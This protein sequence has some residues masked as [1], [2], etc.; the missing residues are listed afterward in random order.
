MIKFSALGVWSHNSASFKTIQ[1]FDLDHILTHQFESERVEHPPRLYDATLKTIFDEVRISTF[2][3]PELI[4]TGEMPTTFTSNELNAVTEGFTGEGVSSGFGQLVVAM[5]VVGAGT[6]WSKIPR[7]RCQFRNRNRNRFF[8]YRGPG[9]S[10]LIQK[11][12]S[13]KYSLPIRHYLSHPGNRVPQQSSDCRIHVDFPLNFRLHLIM[14]F[15][16][17]GMYCSHLCI[18]T[19]SC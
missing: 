8:R 1:Y 7:F 2:G 14:A 12:L 9:K 4:E 18:H 19:L 13:D 16:S 5:G 17:I 6:G 10:A 15:T 3:P 11:F